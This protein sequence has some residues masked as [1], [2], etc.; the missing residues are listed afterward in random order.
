MASLMIS[1]VLHSLWKRVFIGHDIGVHTP[2]EI[3]LL[4][5]VFLLLFDCQPV[6]VPVHVDFTTCVS[7]N[8][9]THWIHLW[10]QAYFTRSENA[11]SKV[12]ISGYI[13]QWRSICLFLLNL[14]FDYIY[15]F[16]NNLPVDVDFTT[17]VFINQTS[18]WNH[19]WFQPY[20]TRSV[21]A[22]S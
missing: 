11:F 6:D 18:S 8:L 1:N 21:N 19:P 5:S 2:M 3:N 4:L 14:L 9:L 7:I 16:W 17:Y 13:H 12:M 15:L 22:F 10:F 20:F